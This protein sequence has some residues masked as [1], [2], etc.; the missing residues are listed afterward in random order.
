MGFGVSVINE[1]ISAVHQIG[2]RPIAHGNGPY[3]GNVLEQ[4]H[5]YDLS[6]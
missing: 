1:T 4:F 2:E 6:Q 5:R 3:E